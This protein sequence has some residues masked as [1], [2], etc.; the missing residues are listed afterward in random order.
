MY[1]Y[2]WFIQQTLTIPGVFEADS[3]IYWK[4]KKGTRKRAGDMDV[5]RLQVINSAPTLCVFLHREKTEFL[6]YN[7]SLNQ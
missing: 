6:S 2:L 1:L 3:R 4:G 5:F 7:Y